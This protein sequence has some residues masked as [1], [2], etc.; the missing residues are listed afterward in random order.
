[1]LV[2]AGVF[3]FLPWLVLR[4]GRWMVV[5]DRGEPGVPAE[6][7][8]NGKRLPAE[9]V[10]SF[11]TRATSGS[12]MPRS[13]VVAELHDGTYEALGPICA[14]TWTAHYA[15][16]AATWMGLPFRYSRV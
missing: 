1:M 8:Y 11:S 9:R 13:T 5:Y 12:S 4:R 16:Q 15:Q 2:V 10:R 7:R 3:A 6:I 14:S